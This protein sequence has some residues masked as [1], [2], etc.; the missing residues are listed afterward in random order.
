MQFIYSKDAG[1]K[2][3]N[4]NTRDYSHIFKVRRVKKSE[5]LSFR[6]L[7]DD[8]LYRYNLTS[9]DR[10]TATLELLSGDMLKIEAKKSLHVGWCIVDPK[11]IEKTLPF[12]NELGVSK[13]SFVYCEYS[14]RNFKIDLK[15]VEKILINSCEQCGRSS[16][17]QIE[18]LE[19]LKE[20]LALYPQSKIF[21]FGG[22]KIDKDTTY[23]S[24]LIGSEGGF[25][26]A[27]RESMK[28]TDILSLD[29]PMILKSQTAVLYASILGS[30]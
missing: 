26:K 11:T 28:D 6:N 20:Y 13:I 3:L 7:M 16:L 25:S 21:D 12:L 18:I 24:F 23:T 14:Q 5:V 30:L 2:I 22:K 29:N 9:I 27:E 4:L 15:R 10:K 1:E 17:M 8:M 19:N